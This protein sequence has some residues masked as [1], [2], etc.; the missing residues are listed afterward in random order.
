MIQFAVY[1]G[2]RRFYRWLLMPVVPFLLLSGFPF[3]A[4]LASVIKPAGQIVRYG[5]RENGALDR[6]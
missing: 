5:S 4:V 3:L 1:T 6:V 2:D